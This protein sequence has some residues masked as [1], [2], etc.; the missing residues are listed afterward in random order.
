MS[1]KK[2]QWEQ[3]NG[4]SIAQHGQIEKGLLNGITGAHISSV[5]RPVLR[6]V[7]KTMLC[8]L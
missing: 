6:Q 5:I 7:V 3:N 8:I 1:H 2:Q 4:R